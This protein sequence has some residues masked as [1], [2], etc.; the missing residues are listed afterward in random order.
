MDALNLD[1]GV[2]IAADIAGGFGSHLA[3]QQLDGHGTTPKPL[4]AASR[5]ARFFLRDTTGRKSNFDPHNSSDPEN[6]LDADAQ[7]FYVSAHVAMSAMA[8]P[9][10]GA[11]LAA[12]LPLQTPCSF[13]EWSIENHTRK[14]GTS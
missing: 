5:K 6:A 1:G 3:G 12:S 2:V 10:C 9:R 4:N 13:W 14:E 8:I 11:A 7:A